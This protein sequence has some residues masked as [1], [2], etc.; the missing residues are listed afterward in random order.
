MNPYE[1]TFIILYFLFFILASVIR[2]VYSRRFEQP[3]S[4]PDRTDRSLS[5]LPIFGMLIL[6]LIYGLTSWLDFANYTLPAWTGWIGAA[7]FGL[8]D[9]LLWR[10]HADLGRQWS[11]NV[12]LQHEHRLVTTGVYHRIR[13]P[14]YSAHLVWGLA[15]PLL[16]WNWL[17]GFSMLAFSL[18]LYLYR[19]GREEKMMETKFGEEYEEYRKRTGMFI[20]KVF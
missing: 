5:A 9:W 17:A 14:M 13:H 18:P 2:V 1:T 6:P 4:T 19:V 15:Q 10:S 12:E 16:L 7:L 20:P 3:R 11:I 8:A